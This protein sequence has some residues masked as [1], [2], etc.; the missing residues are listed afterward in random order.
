MADNRVPK[1]SGSDDLDVS[2]EPVARK[3][4]GGGWGAIWYQPTGVQQMLGV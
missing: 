1:D 4:S 2:L 3:K